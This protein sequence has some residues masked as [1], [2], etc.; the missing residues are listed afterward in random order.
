MT[1]RA[2][3]KYCGEPGRCEIIDN[4]GLACDAYDAFLNFEG[5]CLLLVVFQTKNE[6]ENAEER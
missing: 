5:A 2:V 1:A 3:G 4:H 6:L